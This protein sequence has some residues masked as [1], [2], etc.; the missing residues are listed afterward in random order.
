MKSALMLSDNRFDDFKMRVV[1]HLLWGYILILCATFD[2]HNQYSP[3]KTAAQAMREQKM[4]KG[5]K[6]EKERED[7]KRRTDNSM[8]FR[9]SQCDSRTCVCVCVSEL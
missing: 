1:T 5:R 8:Q 6:R 2:A 9:K 4:M 7:W 3:S